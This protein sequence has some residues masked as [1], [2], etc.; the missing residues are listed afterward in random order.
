MVHAYRPYDQSIQPYDFGEDA[1]KRTCLW[2]TGLPL[3]VPTARF[4]GRMVMYKGKL[5]ERW[6]NQTDSGQNRLGPSETRHIERARTYPGIAR[7]KAAQ[8]GMQV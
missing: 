4:P 2:L 5:V 1:S 6:S 3:L 7:A 8:W